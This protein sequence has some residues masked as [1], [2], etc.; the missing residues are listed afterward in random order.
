MDYPAPLA[1]GNRS[2][3]GRES[4]PARS[5]PAGAGEPPLSQRQMRMLAFIQDFTAHHPYP[6]TMREITGA[7][8]ISGTSVTDHNLWRLEQM[9]YL[10]RKQGIARGI[11][12]T[13][14]GRRWQR[15][16]ADSPAPEVAA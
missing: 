10:T 15:L 4:I 1:Q 9:E 3:Q 5:G 13:W 2:R 11:L 14:R 6:P 7:C 12:L 16:P 8:H